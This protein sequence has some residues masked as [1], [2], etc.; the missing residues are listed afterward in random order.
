MAR[1][2]R[3]MGQLSQALGTYTDLARFGDTSVGGLPAELIA[4]RARCALLAQ[5]DRQTE[6]RKEAAEL[7]DLLR[8]GQLQLSPAVY[9]I[10]AEEAAAWLGIDRSSEAEALALAEAVAWISDERNLD[11]GSSGRLSAVRQNRL[12]T[13]LWTRGPMACALWWAARGIFSAV[14]SPLCRR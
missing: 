3:K 2:Q 12:V 10:H 13:V 1:N 11:S 6:S 5:M 4:R 14:G 7:Y 9:D 8:R